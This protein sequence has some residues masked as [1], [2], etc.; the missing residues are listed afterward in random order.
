VCDAA[1]Y[2]SRLPLSARMNGNAVGI[3]FV[4]LELDLGLMY[5]RFANGE[6]EDDAQRKTTSAHCSY[7]AA[8]LN[9]EWFLDGRPSKTSKL[10]GSVQPHNR[11]DKLM[12]EFG[13]VQ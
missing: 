9:H 10:L 2:R 4:N 11:W 7:E 6:Y 12:A 3:R 5:C 1:E 8:I 13:F